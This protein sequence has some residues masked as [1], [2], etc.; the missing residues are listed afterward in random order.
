MRKYLVAVL[1]VLCL[2][3]P[4]AAVQSYTEPY[5]LSLSPS[6]EMNVCW[7]LAEPGDEAWVEFG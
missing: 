2:A 3:L 7:L 6:S 1:L 5:L 4:A